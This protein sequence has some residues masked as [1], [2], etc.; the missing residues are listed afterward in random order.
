[1]NMRKFYKKYGKR[2]LAAFL[3]VL[4]LV[5]TPLL[6]YAD[7]IDNEI[8]SYDEI[9]NR[10]VWDESYSIDDSKEFDPS[11]IGIGA[12]R[13]EDI[14]SLELESL[15]EEQVASY[16]EH[17]SDEIEIPEIATN[18]NSTPINHDN[19]IEPQ[20]AVAVAPAV[21]AITL[22]LACLFSS[23]LSLNTPG[24]GVYKQIKDLAN[25]SSYVKYRGLDSSRKYSYIYVYPAMAK[26]FL[27]KLNNSRT[28][29]TYNISMTEDDK[30]VLEY[31]L[32]ENNLLSN[33]N[34]KNVNVKAVDGYK[35]YYIIGVNMHDKTNCYVWYTKD[36]VAYACWNPAG[37]NIKLYRYNPLL[38]SD[39]KFETMP[40]AESRYM[41][42]NA[43][44]M[45]E[46]ASTTTYDGIEHGSS[47]YD[48][49]TDASRCLPFTI[50]YSQSYR[51]DVENYFTLQS[52][53]LLDR[54]LNGRV[55]SHDDIMDATSFSGTIDNILS[56]DKNVYAQ[57]TGVNKAAG[58]IIDLS[59]GSGSQ[60]DAY[61]AVK[62]YSRLFY[63]LRA[64]ADKYNI[65]ITSVQFNEFIASFYKKYVNGTSAEAPEQSKEIMDKF[66]V[67][68]GG[69]TPNDNNDDNN[70]NL[71][72]RLV[73]GFFS[74]CVAGGLIT[75][76]PDYSKDTNVKN[77][78]NIDNNDSPS[79][80][81]STGSGT[82]TGTGSGSS[83][84]SSTN[85]S[86]VLEYLKN[87][88]STLGVL[89]AWQNP[90]SLID[91]LVLKLGIPNII[92]A[93]KNI[94]NNVASAL[95][96]DDLFDS[97]NLPSHFSDVLGVLNSWDF[98]NLFD[99]LSSD[100]SRVLYYIESQSTKNWGSLLSNFTSI[101]FKDLLTN[102]TRIIENLP[103]ELVL[104]F[105]SSDLFAGIGANI[106][107]MP[108]FLSNLLGLGA[109]TLPE[110]FNNVVESIKAIPG[111]I[112]K[113]IPSPPGNDNIDGEETNDDSGF[114]N[115][116]NLFMLNLL[117]I[118]LLIILFMNCL[119]FIVLVFNIPASTALIPD[120]MLKGIEYM[121]TIQLPLFG[122]S[123]YTLLLS[124]AYFVIFMTI[125]MTIRRKIDKLHI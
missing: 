10:P 82:G 53:L 45:Y 12:N 31:A 100:L 109:T 94:G 84:G 90:I 79:A 55:V 50:I 42:S 54:S 17:E 113:I 52:A 14:Q 124:C 93:T 71:K 8:F 20:L 91:T 22:I 33:L 74:F 28:G 73:D 111:E 48:Y 96:L 110:L 64:L 26:V 49:G 66:V 83:T 4:L 119:R 47:M 38:A 87:I 114:K 103:N 35:Y 92:D 77:N 104:G 27:D 117:I 29:S 3:S 51:T 121:K 23:A 106:A 24:E 72:K 56:S 115:F 16:F 116:L 25:S 86:G 120:D 81:G 19:E 65:S 88:L 7:N 67:I 61:S 105:I 5:Q 58:K 99:S 63:I 80:G 118:V 13:I 34:P 123:L 125:I 32:S 122:V 2:T 107:N 37:D 18:S 102:I 9:T 59:S 89:N 11:V 60:T 70:Y 98:D 44:G 30:R 62:Q 39:S 97:L 1:M 15:S 108:L 75:S 57:V 46:L 40:Y 21:G 6:S 76:A 69:K 78:I 36:K 112:G 41:L 101:G 95:N 85:L 68:N 43:T